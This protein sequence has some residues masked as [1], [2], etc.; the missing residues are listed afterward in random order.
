MTREAEAEAWVHR[1]RRAV[2]NQFLIQS[3]AVLAIVAPLPLVVVTFWAVFGLASPIVIRGIL[4]FWIIATLAY[5]A[6]SVYART[7]RM[8]L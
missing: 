8:E 7:R 2:H 4:A 6:M 5:A 1:S 3:L